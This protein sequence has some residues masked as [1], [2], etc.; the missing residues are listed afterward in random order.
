MTTRLRSVLIRAIFAPALMTCLAQDLPAPKADRVGFPKGYQ[1]AFR[2]LRTTDSAE[3]KTVIVVYGNPP[4]ASAKGGKYPYGSV[5]VMETWSTL[6]DAQKNVLLSG[7]HFR[8]DKVTGLHVMRKEH[9]FGEAYLENR[10]GEWEY[11]EYRPD[12]TYITPPAASA[13]CA[14]CHV[15]AGEA[16]DFVYGGSGKQ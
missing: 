5:I 10:T 14:S 11:V 12:G 15:K 2:Q 13:K 1:S 9:G 3:A 4:A 6:Q 16:R 8:K 7:G